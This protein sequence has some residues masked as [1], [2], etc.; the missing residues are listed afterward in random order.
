MT[1]PGAPQAFLLCR[2]KRS[3]SP[4]PAI[5]RPLMRSSAEQRGALARR[6][7]RGAAPVAVLLLLIS[8][9]VLWAAGSLR[10][11]E[12]LFVRHGVSAN[13]GISPE[14]LRAVGRQV[15]D[16]FAG[17]EEPLQARAAVYGEE[18]DLFTDAEAA[19][20]AD[21][22]A[23]F[24]RVERI[25]LGAALFLL[26]ALAA[27]AFFER[28][29]AV[30]EAVR[31]LMDGAVV[32]AA[33]VAAVGLASIVAFDA[34]FDLFHALGFPQGNYRFDTRSSYLVR[35]FPFGFWRD[36]T[37]LIGVLALAEAG[38]LY[39]AGRAL[40]PRAAAFGARPS[41]DGGG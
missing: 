13:T 12:A 18:R 39:A 9:N 28:R 27:S 35:I 19:H 38:V 8:A 32:T 34:V 36:V 6:T 7:L 33:F 41:I 22:K 1:E 37:L 20:M 17:D 31:W 4:S 24:R 14:G 21:V 25:Q 26:A 40:R 3:F 2:G 30:A 10:L 29:C 5:M 15:Q 23:L 11:Y 16:Y